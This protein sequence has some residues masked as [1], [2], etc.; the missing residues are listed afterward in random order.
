M[1]DDEG[2]NDYYIGNSINP[3]KIKRRMFYLKKQFV[4]HSKHFSSRLYKLLLYLKKHFVPRS[5]HFSSRLYKPI[6]L[7]FTGQNSLFVLRQLQNT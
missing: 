7:Y 1:E 5:K 6:S 2:N 3:S 4:P